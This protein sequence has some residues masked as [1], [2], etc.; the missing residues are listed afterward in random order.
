MLDA[1]A[2]P[3]IGAP[4]Y[5]APPARS[6]VK[7]LGA[8]LGKL[9]IGFAVNSPAGKPVHKDCLSAIKEATL[10]LENLGH[11]VEE[12]NLNGINEIIGNT[13]MTVL[14]TT[15]AWEIDAWSRKIGKTPS[16]DD[17]EPATWVIREIGKQCNAVDYVDAIYNIH[18][19]TRD[20]DHRFLQYD[21]LV[22][23]VLAE[24]PV[25]LGSFNGTEDDPLAGSIRHAEYMPF[26]PIC[27]ITGRP[28]MSVPLYWNNENLPIGVHFIGKYGDEATLFRLASQL[29]NA[30]PWDDKRPPI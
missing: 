10:L 24:P 25:L 20:F 15:L 26:T 1:T 12:I 23:S 9:R 13:N 28:A 8:D 29:E 16:K 11:I 4:Y 18:K 7:E 19:F 5:A 17:F 30:K 2:G 27:N 6:F 3:D 21:I 22:T 14:T